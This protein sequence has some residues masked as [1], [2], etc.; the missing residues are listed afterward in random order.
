MTERHASSSKSMFVRDIHQRYTTP[1]STHAQRLAS[2]RSIGAH[3][4]RA[5]CSALGFVGM[6]LKVDFRTFSAE[7]RH[8]LIFI[9]RAV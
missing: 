9:L 8:G 7:G 3:K 5:V 2:S 1:V 6:M 4:E